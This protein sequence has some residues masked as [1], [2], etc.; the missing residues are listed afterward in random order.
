MAP[1]NLSNNLLDKWLIRPRLRKRP[2]IKQIRPGKSLHVRKLAMQVLG[3]A[4]NDFGAPTG[5]ILAFK[6][7]PADA[8]VQKNK[9]PV[10]R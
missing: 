7:V 1:R 5:L 3:E 9:F 2:H 8:P 6:N 10:N 4:V